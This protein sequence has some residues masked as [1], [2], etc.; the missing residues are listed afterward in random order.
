[1]NPTS[2][3]QILQ[4][5]KA[6][7]SAENRLWH[8]GT[9]TYT[10]AGLATLFAWLLW[11]DF[12]WALKDRSISVVLQVMLKKFGASDMLSGAMIGS[13]P[14]IIAMILSPIVSYKSDR[15]RGRW[16][17]RIPFI[18]GDITVIVFSMVGLG[19]CP[20]FGAQIHH[21]LGANSP[22]LNPS[23]L[24]S[25]A[26]FWTFFDMASTVANSVF[27]GLVNDVV[28]QAIV[29]RF[30]GMFRAISLIAGIVFNYW[31]MGSAE[32]HYQWIFIGFGIFYGIGFTM[33]CLRIKEGKYPPPPLIE[34]AE[35]G[36][37]SFIAATKTYFKDCF[38]ISYYVWGFAAGTLAM[39]STL[40]INLFTVFYAK[41]EGMSMDVFG[42][43]LALTYACSLVLAYPLGWL[44]DKFHP[45]RVVIATVAIYALITLWGGIYA[46][47]AYWFAIAFVAHG[48]V[49]GAYFTASA[50][51]GMRLFPSS[52]FAQIG[53]AGGLISSLASITIGPLVGMLLDH[54]HHAYRF[55]FLVAGVLAVLSLITHL[56]FYS[57]FIQLGGPDHY[58]APE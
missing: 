20:W 44:A 13:L 2:E 42:K 43:C 51:L 18:L 8:I 1:M 16:G 23:I 49:S 12:T 41:S 22:G 10:A 29:G 50:S 36:S 47:S 58:V 11:G 9:L 19:L 28:P 30:C 35:S 34:L 14:A 37:N 3:S 39:V 45:L 53:S 38:G 31:F 15:H 32:A 6:G 27:G 54:L 40:S 17:R 46:R 52:K 21:I 4:E 25:F 55:T 48:V 26:V 57:K 5:N 24:M 7:V 33:T 56:V